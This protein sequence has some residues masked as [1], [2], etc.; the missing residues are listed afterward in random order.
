VQVKNITLSAE[1]RLI[2]RA[3]AVAQQRATTLNQLF[4]EWLVDPFATL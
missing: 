2:V 3:R 1:E 4:R